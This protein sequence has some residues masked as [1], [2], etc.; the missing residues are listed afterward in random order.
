MA[1]LLGARAAAAQ[2]PFSGT[3]AVSGWQHAPWLSAAERKTWKPDSTLLRGTIT[4]TDRKV[5][6]PQPVHC[7][8]PKYELKAVPFGYLFEGGLTAPKTQA[9]KLGFTGSQVQTLSPGCEIDFF[10]LKPGTALFALSNII[11][12]ITKR[13]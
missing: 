5:I 9:R 4:F 8:D 1:A 6:A 7:D 13:P 11:Y 10:M 3:W 12:T 2:G